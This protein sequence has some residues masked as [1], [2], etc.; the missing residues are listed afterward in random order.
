[1]GGKKEDEELDWWGMINR[2]DRFC[3]GA[4]AAPCSSTTP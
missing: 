1:M 3:L 4:R 2:D